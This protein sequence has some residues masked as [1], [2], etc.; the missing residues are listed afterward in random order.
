[1]AKKKIVAKKKLK[2]KPVV[3]AKAKGKTK[4]KGKTKGKA[5]LA[6]PVSHGPNRTFLPK[7]M[8]PVVRTGRAYS[9]RLSVRILPTETAGYLAAAKKAKKLIGEWVR[10]TLNVA[11]GVKAPKPAVV[12]VTKVAAKA[13]AKGPFHKAMATAKAGRKAGKRA[14]T[15]PAAD[16][17]LTDSYAEDVTEMVT[18][19]PISR[20]PD[21]AD[22]APDDAFDQTPA[23]VNTAE[24]GLEN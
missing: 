19:A 14:A 4:V 17:V 5:K 22:L 15:L 21:A 7:G 6:L 24:A 12:V 3:K 16:T 1:M 2:A 23:L 10:A 13:K 8:K 11:A 18:A 20:E 9:D